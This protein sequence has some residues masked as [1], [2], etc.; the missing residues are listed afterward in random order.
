MS[1]WDA[2]N[3]ACDA[4]YD[5]AY[6]DMTTAELDIRLATITVSMDEGPTKRILTRARSNA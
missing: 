6:T 3:K 2:I 1:E 5:Y 4:M